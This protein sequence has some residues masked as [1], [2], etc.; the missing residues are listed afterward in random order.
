MVAV[1]GSQGGV[2]WWLAPCLVALFHEADTRD[3]SRSHAADGS[4]GDAAHQSRVSDHN[5]SEGWVCGADI[6]DDNDQP[7]PGVDLLRQH[8]VASRDPRVK[9][10]IRNGTIWKA[11]PNRGLPA[12]TP[13]PYT[14]LNDHSHHLHISVY[15]TPEA[16]NDTGPWWPTNDEEFDMA[17][18][19]EILARLQAI[20][21]R[22]V[23]L[24][25]S[26]DKLAAKIVPE[27]TV[28]ADIRLTR[29]IA[30]QVGVTEIS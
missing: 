21:L 14:G 2:R 6:D 29:D 19:D 10:L 15:N 7:S 28:R 18:S 12:W 25:A 30:K 16:R 24:Q 22:E 4:I 5:P 27:D 20:E 8:L 1:T 23:A 9:Y 26:I 13:Q 11:Y 17:T 3:S